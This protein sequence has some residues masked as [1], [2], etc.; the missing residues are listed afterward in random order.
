V[1]A[2]EEMMWSIKWGL[3]GATD[4]SV[5][6][7]FTTSSKPL[8]RSDAATVVP[9]ELKTGSKV[10]TGAEHQGQVILY[11]LLLTERYQQLCQDGLLM[12]VPGI[13]SNRIAA[14]A[15]HVRGLVIARNNY[16][17]AIA[18][19]KAVG[20]STS[21]QVFPPMIRKRRECERCFQV[22]ECV[23]HHAAV[24]NG[25]GE[26]SGLDEFFT[27]KTGHLT[28]SDFAY[29]KKWN[30]MLDLE[31]QYAEKNLRSLW[32]QVGWKREKTHESGTCVADLRLVSD[33]P[34]ASDTNAKR[35]LR[36]CRD[37][38]RR[39][40]TDPAPSFEEIRFRVDERVIISTESY[41]GSALLV[42][43]AKGI[44]RVIE[45]DQITVEAFQSVPQIVTS[46]QSSVGRDFT[47][48]L[49]KDAIMS[50]LTRAKENLV[51]LFVGPPPEAVT[52]GTCVVN[53]P[54]IYSAIQ[55]AAASGELLNHGDSRRR[56]LI[57]DLLRP[58]FKS[59]R[60]T[61]LVT[62][63]FSNF[64]ASTEH[65]AVMVTTQG[66]ALLDEFFLL[67]IDQQRAVYRVLNTLDYALVLGMPGTGKTS[68]IAFAVRILLYL[69]FSVLVTSYTHSAVDNLLLK[70]LEHKT[71]ML[72]VGNATQVHPLLADYT[73]DRQV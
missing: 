43:I 39:P 52:A 15:T 1:L 3:K 57:V 71:P 29:F 72:R 38:R 19:V 70:L 58:R 2:T 8:S 68:T 45:R 40:A 27:G 60:V 54:E 28:E 53:R 59:N 69:G 18:R 46:G 73:L 4:A 50:G 13:E 37:P 22:N 21:A 64:R 23:L 25:S 48:R 32:L 55:A 30:Y 26:S 44:V 41:D 10:Y 34:A 47:W 49:D 67:N 35:K 61:E 36:F 31:Q 7:N 12:Y 63:H 9:L 66:K 42:H 33:E 65:E 14:M 24:E 17:S 16:A 5:Q 20:S 62:Q 11:T 6:A 56:N 51:R